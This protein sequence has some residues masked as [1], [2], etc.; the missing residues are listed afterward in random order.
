M[1]SDL[2]FDR[3]QTMIAPQ[4]TFTINSS[5]SELVDRY[6]GFILDQFGVMH[7]G[8]HALEGASECVHELKK[9]GKRLIILSNSSA[10]AVSTMEK[11][12]KLGFD[13]SDFAG[14][15]TSG[16]EAANHLRKKYQGK[17][18][19]FL[20]WK[21]PKVPSPLI[22]LEK[23]GDVTVAESLDN[24]DFILL[25][26]CEVIRGIGAD[27]EASEES[28]GGYME[29][30]DMSEVVEPLLQRCLQRSLPMVCANPDFIY[31]RP[32]HKSIGHMPGKIAKRY[33]ELGGSVVSFGKPHP[34]HFEACI[35]KLGLPKDKVVH[36]GDSMHHDIAGANEAGIQ[37][38]LVA[39]GVHRDELGCALGSIPTKEAVDR[40]VAKYK[41]SPTHVVPLLRF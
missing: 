1:T 9:R 38:I 7:N 31:V 40:L 12:P 15:T 29:T 10:L 8:V 27:G 3:V 25:H 5:I 2:T 22:F 4:T 28:L 34:K 41:Y 32:D 17:R 37:S 35:L 18:A 39:G 13:R 24:A 36:V 6:D 26:G 11:L 19:L 23:C 30:G 16:E 20:T 21:T 33:E 14:A